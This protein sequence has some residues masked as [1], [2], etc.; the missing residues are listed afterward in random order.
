MTEPAPGGAQKWRAHSVTVNGSVRTKH[1][2]GGQATFISEV[3]EQTKRR[4]HEIHLDYGKRVCTLVHIETG[5]R[6]DVPF[7][8]CNSW[9][10]YSEEE[11]LEVQTKPGNDNAKRKGAAA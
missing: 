2:G 4:E 11:M 5:N 7:E 10:P 9:N 1:S 6:T 3:N 8:S